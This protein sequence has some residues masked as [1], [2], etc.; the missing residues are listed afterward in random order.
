MRKIV[1]TSVLYIGLVITGFSATTLA[2]PKEE[3][4][5]PRGP[6]GQMMESIIEVCKADKEKFCPDLKPGEGRILRCFKKHENEVS[7]EC[8]AELKKAGANRR[9][10]MRSGKHQRKDDN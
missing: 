2:E 9:G 10:K 3:K 4:N 6:R 5:S 8:K 7:V 1:C